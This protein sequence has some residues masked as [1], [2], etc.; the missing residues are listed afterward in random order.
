MPAHVRKDD[1]VIILAGDYRGQTGKVVRVMPKDQRVVV[2]GPGID[3]ISKNMRP[4]RVN[5]Q[6]GR[7]ELDR[8]F[9]IS[10]VAP[11]IDG[12]P[13]R[14]RFSQKKDGSKVRVAARGGKELGQVRG[15]KKK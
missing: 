10:N 3:G 4:S 15:P 5:P 13:T 6:G 1:D 8:S 9:H 7:V 12:K 14:V 11:A 2:R